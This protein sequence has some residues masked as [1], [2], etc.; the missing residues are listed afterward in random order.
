[1]PAAVLGPNVNFE[2]RL[3]TD[4]FANQ[5]YG[6]PVG[7]DVM[8]GSGAGSNQLER[9]AIAVRRKWVHFRLVVIFTV[10]RKFEYCILYY[11]F[12]Q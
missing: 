12:D 6:A 3:I 2:F 8:V 10:Q 9:G 1:V 7:G 11:S 5:F 4:E